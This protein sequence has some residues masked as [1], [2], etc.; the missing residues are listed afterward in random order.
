MKRLF[1]VKDCKGSV[2]PVMEDGECLHP[3]TVT[4]E[5]DTYFQDK[6]DAKDLRDHC[7][8][9]YIND[10]YTV[11]RGPDHIGPHGNKLCRMR[12]QPK[13]VASYTGL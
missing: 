2:R 9:H 8:K 5:Q 12:L 1:C 7:N 10:P 3:N 11:S 4:C 13:Q 6:Q